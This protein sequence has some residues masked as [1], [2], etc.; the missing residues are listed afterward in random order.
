MIAILWFE[1]YI[2]KHLEVDLLG[3]EIIRFSAL[4]SLIG[5]AFPPLYSVN[6][7]GSYCTF[8]HKL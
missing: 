6:T 5:Y 2:R 4:I 8:L 3:T 1:S 7:M